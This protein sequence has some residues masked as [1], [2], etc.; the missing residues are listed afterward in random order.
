MAASAGVVVLLLTFLLPR[1]A[2][3]FA[4]TRTQLPLITRFFVGLSN[5]LSAFPLLTLGIFL[6]LVVSAVFMLRS[7]KGRAAF[8][9]ILHRLPV[10]RILMRELALARL[11]RTLNNLLKSGVGA[12]EAFD[13]AAQSVGDSVYRREVMGIREDAKKGLSISDSIRAREKHFPRMFISMISVGE[14]TGTMG[15]S[16]E[17]L[18]AFYDE[19][20]DRTLKNLVGI[21][22]PALLL[23]M[24]F[25][26]GGVAL[27]VL[28]PIYQLV[29][30]LR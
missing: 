21:L 25:V 6:A 14:K 27:S 1:L 8:V 2:N 26:V 7:R 16:L 28:L 15:K 23:V 13:I 12:L 30:N 3:V 29:G 5:I 9:I 22:E 11:T 4:G 18:A 24:G 17:T 10:S 20:A 19:E